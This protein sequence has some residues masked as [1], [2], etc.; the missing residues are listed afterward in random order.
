FLARSARFFRARLFP[1]V[2]LL[3]TLVV[4]LAFAQLDPRIVPLAQQIVAA[5][6]AAARVNLYTANVNL[7][8]EPLII[9]IN[10]IASATGNGGNY[11]GAMRMYEVGCEL[12]ER[13]NNVRGNALCPYHTGNIYFRLGDIPEAERRFNLAIPALKA[14]EDHLYI[15]RAY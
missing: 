5:P 1:P 14:I 10:R 15:A 7:L 11:Q 8:G 4:R 2:L 13:I 6:D 3:V 9:E 12:S